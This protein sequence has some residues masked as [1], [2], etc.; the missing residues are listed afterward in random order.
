MQ[1]R[2]LTFKLNDAHAVNAAFYGNQ[3]MGVTSS[4]SVKV[5]PFRLAV[6]HAH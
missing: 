4:E 3:E 1:Q 2:P 5:Q 6:C